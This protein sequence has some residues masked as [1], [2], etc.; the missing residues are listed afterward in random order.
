[1]EEF[2][3][4]EGMTIENNVLGLFAIKTLLELAKFESGVLKN[5][6]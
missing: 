5:S 3:Q 2:F 4:T 6:T 1:M